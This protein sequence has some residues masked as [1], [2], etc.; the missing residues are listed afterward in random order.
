M[1]IPSSIHNSNGVDTR[2]RIGRASLL[3]M[4]SY[5]ISRVIGFFR[6]WTLA[7][8][9]GATQSTDVY[10]ASFTVPDFLNYVM[11]TGALSVTFIPVLSECITKHTE[12][13]GIEL[14]RVLSTYVGSVLLVI[15][16]VFELGADKLAYL[17][18]PGF[19]PHQRD[20]LTT[21]LRIVIPG[22]FFFFWGGLAISVQYTYGRFLLPALAPIV[23]NVCIIVFGIMFHSQIGVMGFSIGVLVGAILSHG[24]I[25]WWGLGVLGYRCLPQ[26]RTHSP[27]VISLIKR[28][29]WL[30]VPI[31]LGFSLVITDEWISKFFASSMESRAVSW[32]SYAR[33]EMRIPVAII[34]QVAGVASFPYLAKL[35]AD[36]NY[37][38]YAKTLLV[39]IEKLWILSPLAAIVL[40][41]HALPLTH[42]IFGGGAFTYEDLLAT[43]DCLKMYGTGVIFWI[44][45]IVIARGFYASQ[46]TWLPS[47]VGSLI[48][49]LCIPLYPLLGN[50]LGYRGLAL[51]GSIGIG[52]YC[53]CLWLLL[54]T[55]LKKHSVEHALSGFYR[56]FGGWGL[57]LLG[58]FLLSH[59]I[60]RLGIYRG[61]RLTGLLDVLVCSVA[62]L[63]VGWTSVRTFMKR[64]TEGKALF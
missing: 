9:V 54:R 61:T 17:I 48:T 15:V 50:S 27:E 57:V 40:I 20:L 23:Y 43:A 38:V 11:A 14:F 3:L 30:S 52:I 19:S 39:E 64:W 25:Q 18:A 28:Y 56:F 10:Y 51:S 21:L 37:A 33:T 58:C 26:F 44:L 4:G 29:L 7:T 16:L 34:G 31:M 6:E 8:T 60:L 53:L 24:A 2:M 63:A 59:G 1:H 13:V 49:I 22:Q 36:R 45:Q 47:L 12:R 32:L 41:D 5:A 42:F 62:L 35:W 55:H 46:M